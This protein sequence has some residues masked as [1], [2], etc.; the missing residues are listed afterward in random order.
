SGTDE[1][2]R[3]LHKLIRLLLEVSGDINLQF[4]IKNQA[5]G[6]CCSL[7]VAAPTFKFGGIIFLGCK[8]NVRYAVSGIIC[9]T[10]GITFDCAV[11]RRDGPTS[12]T[13]PQN[14]DE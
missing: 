12:S 7:A 14:A 3:H 13:D 9:D 6:F 10:I 8:K 5:A 1:N 11:F 2:H 4:L